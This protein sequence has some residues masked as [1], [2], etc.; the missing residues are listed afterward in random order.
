MRAKHH[1]T[2]IKVKHYYKGEWFE[3]A[4]HT[5]VETVVYETNKKDNADK[6][7]AR[8]VQRESGTELKGIYYPNVEYYLRKDY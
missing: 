3:T 6:V 4:E 7:F 1:Y 2:I 8:L 5:S